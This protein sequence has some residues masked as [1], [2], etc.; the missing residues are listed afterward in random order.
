VEIV[1]GKLLARVEERPGV[2]TGPFVEA[3]ARGSSSLGLEV[4]LGS[5]GRQ[6]SVLLILCAPFCLDVC[7]V[8]SGVKS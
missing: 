5:H 2:V 3:I 8:R 7:E 4:V 6:A 1:C